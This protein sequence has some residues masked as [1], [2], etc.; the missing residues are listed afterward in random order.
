[1]AYGVRV[2]DPGMGIVGRERELGLVE[3]FVVDDDSMAKSLVLEGLAG[4]GKTTIWNEGLDVATR[5]G[6]AVRST[7]CTAADAMWAFS[8]LGDLFDEIPEEVLAALPPVQRRA[9]SAALLFDVSSV[10]STGDRVLGVAALGVL[11]SMARVGPLILAFDDVQWLDD[12]SRAVLTFA[13]HRMPAERIRVLASRRLATDSE[14]GS[15]ELCLG[16]AG[17][18]L[19]VGPV[20]VGALQQ[21]VRSQLSTTF[22]RPTLTRLHQATGGNPMISLEMG[23]ALQRRGHEPEAHEPLPVPSDIRLL[24]ADRLRGLSLAARDFLLVSAALA[25]PSVDLVSAAMIDS[26]S[27]QRSLGEVLDAG[28]MEVDGQRLRFTH[29]LIA[30]VPYEGLLPNDRQALHR[31]LARVV[32]DPEEHARHVALGSDGPDP[33]VADALEAA[34]RHARVRGSTAAAAELTELALSRTPV[35]LPV[36]LTRRRVDAARYLF[37]LGEPGR[38]RSMVVAS[39]ESAPDA[40]CRVSGLLLLATID[41]WIEG[42]AAAAGWCEQALHDAGNDRLLLARCHAALADLAPYDAARLIEHARLAVE[43]IGPERNE[44]VDVLTSALKNVAYHEFRLGRGLSVSFLERAAALENRG[45]PLPVLERVGMYMGM[46]LRFAGQFTAARRWLLQMRECAQDEGD[47]SAL[48][49]ILGH[50]GLLECWAGDYRRALAHVAEG[51]ELSAR[52]GVGS[53]SVTAAQTLA[54]A[55]LGNIDFARRLAFSALAHDEA[56]GDGG[57]MACDL[58]SLGFAE[59]SVGDWEAAAEHL[60]RALAIAEELG[61]QE[62]AI[63]RIHADAVEALIALG[64]IDEAQE[65]TVELER[66]G[67]RGSLWA[68]A[69]AGRCRGMLWAEAGELKT[70]AMVLAASVIDHQVLSMPFEHARTRLLLGCVLRRAG[71]RTVSRVELTEALTMFEQLGTPIFAARALAELGRLG[72]KVGGHVDLTPAEQRVAELVGAGWTNIEV[73]AALFIGVR[74]V[75]SH[76]GRIYRKLG[77]RSRT[78]LARLPLMTTQS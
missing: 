49:N 34:A 57:D 15:T 69:M 32:T 45:E 55:H 47:D 51:L 12:A 54:E 75:E 64:R 72:G 17:P 63:L 10:G 4:I 74:T 33:L 23:R 52:T 48:P 73:A 44:P 42:G 35:D 62:P 71:Q 46:L 40:V 30:S 43:L 26:R 1:M 29:P 25:Q 11:R 16:L 61:V 68:L 13:L 2:V 18:R 39:L 7:R 41:Y 58:R 28:A 21:I 20:T 38:A 27:A 3:T 70:A 36:E 6:I 22:T 24:V 9:L 67:D 65:L 56:L 37:H 19:H 66:S 60:C 8:G 50:L 77:L 59:L 31:R 53:P 14:S 5:R 78:E 76:L